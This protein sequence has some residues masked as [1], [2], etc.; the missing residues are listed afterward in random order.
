LF[1]FPARR[2]F[3]P[4]GRQVPLN[5]R[6][7]NIIITKNLWY[8]KNMGVKGKLRKKEDYLVLAGWLPIAKSANRVPAFALS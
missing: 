6:R 5:Y 1:A 8:N 3:L 7:N 4:A 2:R